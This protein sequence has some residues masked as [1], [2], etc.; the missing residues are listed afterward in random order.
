MYKGVQDANILRQKQ[1]QLIAQRKQE[2]STPM[3]DPK[4][5]LAELQK[6]GMYYTPD[7]A[8]ATAAPGYTAASEALKGVGNFAKEPLKDAGKTLMK[9]M[10]LAPAAY[11]AHKIKEKF[12]TEPKQQ[13]ALSQAIDS[14]PEL[15]R[16]KTEHPEV[17][18]SS[19]QTLKRLSPAIASDPNALRAYLTNAAATGGS[20]DLPTLKMLVDIQKAYR[21]GQGKWL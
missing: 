18:D 4:T 16:A 11:A 8:A 2:L 10:F 1:E 7:F 21:E 15:T 13:K 6:E 14:S 20:A 5:R 17:I 19:H 9:A 12:I 3:Y